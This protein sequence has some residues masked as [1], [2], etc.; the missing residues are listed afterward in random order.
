MRLL[1]AEDEPQTR[2][3]LAHLC[4]QQP[5]LQIVARA[6]TGADAIAATLEHRPEVLLLDVELKDMSGFQVLSALR[7]ASEPLAIMMTAQPQSALQAFEANAFDCLP[8]PVDRNRFN[9]AISRARDRL[10]SDQP[11]IQEVPRHLTGEK[12]RRLFFIAL[13]TID[14]ITAD[15]NYVQ[16]HAEGERYIAR[17][18]LK[19]LEGL[20][21]P[22]GFVRIARERMINLR[23][24]AFAEKLVG[25][26]FEFALRGGDRVA[27]AASFRRTILGQMYKCQRT[28]CASSR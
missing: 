26:V 19:S 25:G 12:G 23:Q 8:K 2:S 4:Q 15:G 17:N 9:S 27:S 18:T 6:N 11:T 10:H 1:I 3:D 20:L 24:V 22:A 28:R 14:S 13:E 16:I 21:A 5:D 7:P